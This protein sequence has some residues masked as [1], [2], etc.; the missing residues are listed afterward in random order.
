MVIHGDIVRHR[1][2]LLL[3]RQSNALGLLVEPDHIASVIGFLCSDDAAAISG[4]MLPVDAAHLPNT[5][6]RGF[7]GGVPWE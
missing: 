5:H 6:Y 1:K 2:L 4:V 3:H 7:A